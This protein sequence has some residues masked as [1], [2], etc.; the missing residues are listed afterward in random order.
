MCW[1]VIAVFSESL[2][3]SDRG[4]CWEVIVDNF[5]YPKHLP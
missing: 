1:E 2:L 3:G 5:S 4:C